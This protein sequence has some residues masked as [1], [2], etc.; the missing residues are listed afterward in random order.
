MMTT[1]RKVKR[2]ARRLHR[3]CVVGGVLDEARA[4]QVAQRVAES[5]RYGSLAIL[6]QFLRLVR[7]DLQ[8]RIAIVESAVPLPGDVRD[9]V[10]DSLSNTYGSGL[11]TSFAVNPALIAGMRIKVGSDVFDGSVRAR[12]AAIEARF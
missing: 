9:G 1:N 2:A 4:R 5:G 10:R 3:V 6:W 12:L 8:R 7:L 11:A